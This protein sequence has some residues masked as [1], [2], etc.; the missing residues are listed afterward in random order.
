MFVAITIFL[1]PFGGLLK[2]FF[3]FMVGIIEC[4]G[5]I[6]TERWSLNWYRESFVKSLLSSEISLH[7]GKN[8]KM[9]PSFSFLWIW[10]IRHAMSSRF[11]SSQSGED[12]LFVECEITGKE[13]FKLFF[14]YC[15]L[16]YNL[17]FV[18]IYGQPALMAYFIRYILIFYSYWIMIEFHYF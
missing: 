9:A 15:M 3:W 16:V 10:W 18:N 6:S 11:I 5:W 4:K 14:L 13:I 17:L 7:P 12:K 1:T 2:I 8:T